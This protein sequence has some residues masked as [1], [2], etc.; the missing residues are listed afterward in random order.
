MTDFSEL[1]GRTWVLVDLCGEKIPEDARQVTLEFMEDGHVA[2]A[3]PVNRYH[4]EFIMTDEGLEV[5][6]LAS[7]MMAGEPEAM[8]RERAYLA[9]IGTATSLG[10]AEGDVL[11]IAVE[12][13][14][15]PLRFEA[16]EEP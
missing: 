12:N 4:G 11:V 3:A 10:L 5:G 1:E 9:A 15:L 16:V 6:P 8:D 2:G 13:Q 7:T 14:E